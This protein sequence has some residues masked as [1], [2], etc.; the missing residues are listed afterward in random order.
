MQRCIQNS[1]EVM[2][3]HIEGFTAISFKDR[4]PPRT[5]QNRAI[6]FIMR[7]NS[8]HKELVPSDS[9]EHQELR[10]RMM[11]LRLKLPDRE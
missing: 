4:F 7:Q 5:V 8:A 6:Y 2:E 3:Y 11:G 9:P 10:A 1:D